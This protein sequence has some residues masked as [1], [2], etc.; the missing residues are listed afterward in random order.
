M[1]MHF[2]VGYDPNTGDIVGLQGGTIAEEVLEAAGSYP[3]FL[4]IS[5]D[6]TPS[7]MGM[8]VRDGCI[9]RREPSLEEVRSDALRT[10][11]EEVEMLRRQHVTRALIQDGIYLRKA[12]EG[13]RFLSLN[14]TPND[15]SAFPMIHAEVGVTTGSATELAELWVRKAVETDAALAQIERQRLITKWRI[16]QADDKEGIES[17]LQAFAG[18]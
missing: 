18:A 5:S 14:A 17:A 16:E 15:L 4:A 7:I 13:R 2:I 8:M 1:T 3:A 9:V 11:V 6:D 12:E 10:L